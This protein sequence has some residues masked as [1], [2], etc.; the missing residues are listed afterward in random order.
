MSLITQESFDEEIA[1][2]CSDPL[3]PKFNLNTAEYALIRRIGRVSISIGR[4]LG[5]IYDKLP[6]LVASI[7]FNIPLDKIAPKLDGKLELDTS[8]PFNL[9]TQ[10]NRDHISEV[11]Q[12]H[13]GEK[14]Y[15]GIGIEV[16]YNFNPNDS[17][18]LR[19]M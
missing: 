18:R 13:I 15:N 14:P 19:K 9:V 17:A 4:R 2:L 3:Y 12:R 5:E 7:A 6:R 10:E 11:V 8:L 1:S 16:R